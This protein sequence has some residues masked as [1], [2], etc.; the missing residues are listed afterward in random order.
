MARLTF[1]LQWH[2]RFRSLVLRPDSDPAP[3]GEHLWVWEG[4]GKRGAELY[5]LPNGSTSLHH[6]HLRSTTTALWHPRYHFC[7]I[8]HHRAHYVL[9]VCAQS[10]EKTPPRH[11]KEQT[12]PTHPSM[13]C[14]PALTPLCTCEMNVSLLFLQQSYCNTPLPT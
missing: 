4:R 8:H 7:I 2:L 5:E 10:Q 13:R 12:W 3:A 11:I 14:S 1:K 9:P 6:G